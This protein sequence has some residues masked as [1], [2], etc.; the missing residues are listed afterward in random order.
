MERE[1]AHL[2]QEEDMAN[3][4]PV[5]R[6]PVDSHDR[7]IFY[8][9]SP[10]P[11]PSI[12]NT[13]YQSSYSRERDSGASYHAT[14]SS[15]GVGSISDRAR[16]YSHNSPPREYATRGVSGNAGS[17]RDSVSYPQ[18]SNI[19]SSGYSKGASAVGYNHGGSIAGSMTGGLNSSLPSG[20]GSSDI[21][22]TVNRSPFSVSGPWS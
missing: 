4:K 7:D 21:K 5:F 16:G 1:L 20:W 22:P 13:G 6:P 11:H 15:V 10:A 19:G 3:P 9:R 8:C 18:F 2:R 14:S 12:S 17:Y